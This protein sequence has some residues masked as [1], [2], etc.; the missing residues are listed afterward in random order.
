[1]FVSSQLGSQWMWRRGRRGIQQPWCTCVPH[2][3]MNLKMKTQRCHQLM[4]LIH[5]KWAP[6]RGKND[7]FLSFKMA[8]CMKSKQN[9]RS[10]MFKTLCIEKKKIYWHILC[11]TDTQIYNFIL[12]LL[13]FKLLLCFWQPLCES[14]IKFSSSFRTMMVTAGFRNLYSIRNYIRFRW[15]WHRARF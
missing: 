4:W 11:M 8:S 3:C 15:K 12:L 1:M 2:H 14:P 6:L 10:L 5:C 9:K 7:Y 13:S